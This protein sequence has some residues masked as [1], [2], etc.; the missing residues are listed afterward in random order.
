[1]SEHS[2]PHHEKPH[3]AEYSEYPDDW[4]RN[5]MSVKKGKSIE[6]NWYPIGTG[7]TVDGRDFIRMVNMNQP[8]EGKPFRAEGDFDAAA[9]KEL[10]DRL[11]AERATAQVDLAQGALQGV[12]MNRPQTVS[13]EAV[14]MVLPRI[15]ELKPG[16]Y[17]E[18]DAVENITN[19]YQLP[20]SGG[21]KAT[22]FEMGRGMTED[23]E[24]Y[25]RLFSLKEEGASAVR[26]VPVRTVEAI[27]GRQVPRH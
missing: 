22:W 15:P 25:L 18:S 2:T 5:T 23:G 24:P 10:N 11:A 17:L 14:T 4:A 27:T 8:V 13:H 21:A 12:G 16:E 20:G 26:D 6:G 9:I 1:M 3:V 19:T 7:K